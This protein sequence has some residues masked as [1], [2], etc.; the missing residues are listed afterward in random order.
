MFSVLNR[1]V[2]SFLMFDTPGIYVFMY[3]CVRTPK[4]VRA[5]MF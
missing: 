4:R 1:T 3:K 2:F 5:I